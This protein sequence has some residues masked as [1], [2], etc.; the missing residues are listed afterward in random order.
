MIMRSI[1][2]LLL[3]QY[4]FSAPLFGQTGQNL[5]TDTLKVRQILQ[6]VKKLKREAAIAKLE[7]AQGLLVKN[8][9]SESAIMS[10]VMHEKGKVATTNFKTNEAIQ[11]TTEA[12]RLRRKF[13]TP[14]RMNLAASLNNLGSD[15]RDTDPNTAMALQEESLS[16]RIAGFGENSLEAAVAYAQLSKIHVVL[17][18]YEKAVEFALKALDI[19]TVKL[20]AKHNLTLSVLNDLATAYFYQGDYENAIDRYEA[21]IAE[22]ETSN[23]ATIAMNNLGYC[24]L[25]SG[26]ADRAIAVAEK[27]LSLETSEMKNPDFAS[28]INRLIANAYLSKTEY[29]KAAE[30]FKK[31][32]ELNDFSQGKE[33]EEYCNAL[34]EYG[35][36]LVQI[37]VLK[38][39]DSDSKKLQIGLSN[40]INGF[41]LLEENFPKKK[42]VIYEGLG[43]L[44]TSYQT[45]KDYKTA[46]HYFERQLVLA[47]QIY[48][49]ELHIGK[50]GPYWGLANCYSGLNQ[51]KKALLYAD[52]IHFCVL[53]AKAPKIYHSSHDQLSCKVGILLKMIENSDTLNIYPIINKTLDDYLGL[54]EETRKAPENTEYKLGTN[55]VQWIT[56]ENVLALTWWLQEHQPSQENIT[57][58]WAISEFTRSR[59][60]VDS[61]KKAK[62]KKIAGVPDHI[63]QSEKKL[64]N[65]LRNLETQ[66]AQL[67]ISGKSE[68]D[69]L[70]V[71]VA[72]PG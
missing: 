15:L 23:S 54:M 8:G 65:K 1:S 21:V 39:N 44:A 13:P 4:F 38:G 34:R 55:Q 24:Y 12:V 72:S 52:S 25:F 28:K 32:L 27:T 67:R 3:I 31:A 2:T 33:S 64:S 35:A 63:V 29:E 51:S 57:R 22:D 37:E 42:Y 61:F 41:T 66:K 50:I 16:I 45:L 9:M 62:A 69:S 36:A 20:G 11:A 59:E 19:R 6:E 7:E 30:Y 40:L 68:T 47:N 43:M 26:E 71:R 48:G 10:D 17:T 46:L 53:Q 58:I 56:F 70:V 14:D 5:T 60:M 49:V 18:Q